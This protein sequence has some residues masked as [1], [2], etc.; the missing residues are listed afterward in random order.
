M[1]VKNYDFYCHLNL[2]DSSVYQ[3]IWYFKSGLHNT[4]LL[5][6]LDHSSAVEVYFTRFIL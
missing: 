3:S 1:E 6:S 5:A 4:K 2:N